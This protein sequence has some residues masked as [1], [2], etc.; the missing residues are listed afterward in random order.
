[1]A[2]DCF[3]VLAVIVTLLGIIASQAGAGKHRRVKL[4]ISASGQSKSGPEVFSGSRFFLWMI[5]AEATNNKAG[6]LLFFSG[7][8]FLEKRLM[9]RPLMRRSYASARNFHMR[10]RLPS[11]VYAQPFFF[12]LCADYA[13]YALHMR[14][15]FCIIMRLCAEF[16]NKYSLMRGHPYAPDFSGAPLSSS[17]RL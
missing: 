15:G 14:G 7:R 12:I 2:Q 17:G 4:S 11:F 13:N 5:R 1:M 10:T 16:L 8:I 3:N 6:L 9:R